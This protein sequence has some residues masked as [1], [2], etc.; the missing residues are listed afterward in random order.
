MA[1]IKAK[2]IDHLLAENQRLR[3]EVEEEKT[4][5]KVLLQELGQNQDVKILLMRTK[6]RELNSAF[7]H[8]KT[9]YDKEEADRG[10]FNARVQNW[11]QQAKQELDNAR[12]QNVQ[13]SNKL[14]EIQG[15]YNP[16][17]FDHERLKIEL[18]QQVAMTEQ[19]LGT[20]KN[21][22]LKCDRLKKE[23]DCAKRQ[24]LNDCE[25]V[26][27]KSEISEMKECKICNETFDH[28]KHQ[29]A[30]ANCGHVL[31]CKSCLTKVG[32]TTGKCPSCRKPFKS[33]QVVAVNLSFI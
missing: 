31:Y 33:N 26:Q 18:Q 11:L 29:P 1:A 21:F 8:L 23:L 28:A 9:L 5:N 10:Q 22:N 32:N 30:K 7:Q 20:S 15:L 25:C 17:F 27:L 4:K 13:L 16:L 14:L 3:N 19:W 24:L 6:C 12:A 2:L